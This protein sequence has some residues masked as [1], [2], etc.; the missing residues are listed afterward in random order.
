MRLRFGSKLK[1]NQAQIGFKVEHISSDWQ[2]VKHNS[3]LD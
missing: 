2:K 1:H 3:A